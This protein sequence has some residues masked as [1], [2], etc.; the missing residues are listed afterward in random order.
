ML[1]VYLNVT[2]FVMTQ[3]DIFLPFSFQKTIKTSAEENPRRINH[4][5]NPIRADAEDSAVF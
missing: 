5:K 4:L 3:R 1:P 2:Q